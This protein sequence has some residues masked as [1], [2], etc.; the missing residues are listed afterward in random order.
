VDPGSAI[1]LE[2]S[3]PMTRLRVERLVSFLPPVEVDRV[4]WEGNTLVIQPAH[5]L[6]RDTT[7]VV[8]IRPDYQDRHGVSGAQWH[9]FAFATGTAPLDTARIEGAVTLRHAPAD[10][11]VVRCFRVGEG[12]TLRLERDRPSRETTA[13]RQGAY[14]LRYLPST[15]ARFVVM[16]FS[17][18]NRNHVFD[19]DSDP[20]AVF[21]DTV[22]MVPA[23]PVVRD[24]D[25]ALIDPREPGSVK[26]IVTNQSG[27]DTARVMIAFYDAADSTR[28]A[29]RAVCDSTGGYEVASV[30]PGN[31]VLRAF[32]D[33][34]RD[35]VPGV[36]PCPSQ[37]KGC[38]EPAVRRPGALRVTPAARIVEPPL[39]IPRKEEP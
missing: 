22:V 10:N 30:K 24:I 23:A 37:P 18:A 5:A 31:Y 11:A 9:E 6:Q 8:R 20:S 27:I 2:F 19:A 38:P 15:R 39:I 28:A 13:N 7:Y 29:Y 34:V 14:R 12:D 35:S 33:A 1:R 17:D 16:A 3:E 26:G 25:L 4:R 36:Y 21:A 32:V